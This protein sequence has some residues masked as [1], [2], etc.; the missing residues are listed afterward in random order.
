MSRSD[1][2][3]LRALARRWIDEGWRAGHAEVVDELHA[4]EFVDHDAAGRPPD[5]A[6]F[7]HGIARLYAAFPDFVATIED[8]VVEPASGA[9]TIRWTGSGTHQGT[10]LGAAATQRRI[11]FKGIEI[12]RVRQG[13]IVERWGEWDG[14][15]LLQQLGA[16]R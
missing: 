9:V 5:S 14:I 1:A 6:G 3:R 15:D 7:K 2:E 8:L 4:A 13:K 16:W 12:L 10:Y 11:T